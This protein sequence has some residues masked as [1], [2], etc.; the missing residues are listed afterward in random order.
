MRG[1][2]FI[3][4]PFV[5]DSALSN[6]LSISF[7][8]M[9]TKGAP[10]LYPNNHPCMQAAV[11]VINRRFSGAAGSSSEMGGTAYQLHMDEIVV[12]RAP[13]VL[14]LSRNSVLEKST[15]LAICACDPFYS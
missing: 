2:I 5:G 14:H 9:K 3:Q 11:E 1:I 15:V 13:S 4:I 6:L 10:C 12:D 8:D 7:N